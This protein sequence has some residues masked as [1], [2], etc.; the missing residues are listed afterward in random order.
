MLHVL[1]LL[2]LVLEIYWQLLALLLMV[3]NFKL[4]TGMLRTCYHSCLF[5]VALWQS[6]FRW[7]PIVTCIW[8]CMSTVTVLPVCFVVLLLLVCCCI[9]LLS[10]FAC[11]WLL[12][13]KVVAS[14][15]LWLPLWSY[16]LSTLLRTCYHGCSGSLLFWVG[17][18]GYPLVVVYKHCRL[19]VSIVASLSF[20]SQSWTLADMLALLLV[21]FTDDTFANG[22][23][24]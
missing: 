17:F 10:M 14:V 22:C 20:C 2:L 3:A 9:L 1:L 15:L 16:I 6:F 12:T 23:Q 7:V 5:K 11:L 24:L 21:I 4:L 18:Y 8:F 19:C 13:N